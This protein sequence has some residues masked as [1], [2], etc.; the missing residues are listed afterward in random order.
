MSTAALA[1]AVGDDGCRPR[2]GRRL[3]KC[4]PREGAERRLRMH[5][6]PEQLSLRMAQAGA[7]QHSV[8]PRRKEEVEGEQHD[9]PRRDV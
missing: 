1:L 5:W 3:R 8:Q 6:L 9:A 2:S 7:T 4:P